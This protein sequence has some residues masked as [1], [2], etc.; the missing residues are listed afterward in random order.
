[1]TAFNHAISEVVV[2]NGV[3]IECR[4]LNSPNYNPNLNFCVSLHWVFLLY[5]P[6][7]MQSNGYLLR[8]AIEHFLDY[9]A[10]H[11]L[12]N[13]TPLQ[14]KNYTDINAEV[15][16]GFINYILD[17]KIPLAVPDRLKTAMTLVSKETGKLPLMA[18]PIV[19]IQKSPGSP[20]L[21]PEAFDDFQGALSQHINILLEKIKF[22]KEVALAKP[23]TAT[24]ILQEIYPEPTK[25][26]LFEWQTFVNKT[27]AKPQHK[28]YRSRLSRCPDDEIRAIASDRYC[29]TKF[30]QIYE[31]DIHQYNC[32]GDSDPFKTGG[33]ANWPLDYARTIN[34]FI[35]HGYPFRVDSNLL[36]AEYGKP[37]LI[38][39]PDDCQDVIKIL[40][41][42]LTR[43]N[44]PDHKGR[45]LQ[46]DEVLSLYYPDIVDMTAILLFMMFQSGWNKETALALDPDNYEHILT[47]TIESAIKV[48][49]SEKNRSQGLDKPFDA[50]KRISMPTRDDD[51]YSFY[52]L[53]R[54]SIELS[55]PLADYSFDF[56]PP[57]ADGRMSP[58]FLCIRPWAEWNKGGRHTSISHPKTFR[59]GVQ[60]FL[61]R[62]EVIDNGKRLTT[63]SEL[64]RRLR[65]TWLL[66]KKKNAPIGLLSMSMGHADR[67]TTD[68]FYDS[69][70]SARLER[71]KRLRSALEEI[72][73]LLRTRQFKGLLSK[74]AQADAI[75][76]LKI[77]HIPGKEKAL[78]GCADQMKPDWV[79]SEIIASTGRKCFAIK[80]CL[81]CS[82]LRIFEDSLPYLM[83][84]E[85]HLAELLDES[86]DSG[87]KSRAEKEREVLQF[88]IDEWGDE[89]EIIEA[90][91]YRRH[92]SPLLPRDLSI[93]EII[94]ESEEYNV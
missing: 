28:T 43:A 90:A 54:L 84:L 81:F 67:D 12:R 32:E 47:G 77:F 76:L 63:A 40:L 9:I 34:T 52:N 16:S 23:Y 51:P 25:E 17:Q 60:Q 1:M 31:R 14:V 20:P 26:N 39:L 5:A 75:A 71:L 68:I 21:S 79:G 92:E 82:Q 66:H 8:S 74:K 58:M 91:R 45:L 78:W 73:T 41:Y 3:R 59:I 33:I 38:A 13:P 42:R 62:Y 7:R 36:Y 64:T 44:R 37:G 10:L 2:A 24:E 61:R 65:P 87:F 94:F 53:I 6:H 49:F 18:L 80:E 86:P 48:V 27:G 4:Y 57:L 85:S 29:V 19:P 30:M 93:L 83:E 70:S 69:S 89:D 55:E 46:V 88:I 11:N 35:T 15:F 22:R 72:I 50:P 56:V